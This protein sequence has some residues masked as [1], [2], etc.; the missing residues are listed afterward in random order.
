MMVYRS[1]NSTLRA[2]TYVKGT[3]LLVLGK[4]SGTYKTSRDDL[5]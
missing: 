3:V 4:R 5:A 2:G 1:S